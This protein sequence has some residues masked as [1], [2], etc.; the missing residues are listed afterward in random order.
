M[1]T[2]EH[3]T[4]AAPLAVAGDRRLVRARWHSKRFVVA[5]I[6]A[7]A[8]RRDHERPPVNLAFVLDRS[9]SMGG[10][11]IRLAAQA[12]EEGIGRLKPTDRFSVV[13]YD[14][15]IEVLV[16]GTHATSEARR[17]AVR[18]L[19][20][21]DARGSTNL[22]GGW[23]TGCEEVASALMA[24]G[25]N[26]TLL[27]SDGLANVGMT[28][29]DELARHA[30]ELRARGV[31]TSTFGVGDDFDEALLSAMAQG[32]GGHFYDI[33]TAEAIADHM[34]S[35]VGETLEVVARDVV[36][37]VTLPGSVR[38]ESLGAFP[39]REAGSR[40]LVAIGDLVS[41][42]EVEVPLRVFFPLGEV[43]ASVPA[44]FGLSDR[45]GVLDGAV[46]RLAWEYADDAA[47]DRQPRDREVDR[48]VARVFAA[49]ARQE[50]VGLNRAGD[51]EA[52][53]GVLEATAH[54]I[55]A[56]AAHDP[57]LRDIAEGLRR[58]G[59]YFERHMLERDRK[60][61]YAMSSYALQARAFD[62]RA[63][64]SGR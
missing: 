33:A 10:R 8:A 21:V 3:T 11:K 62:G 17:E 6:T 55:R 46:G 56:Y 36:L 24:E 50:A 30:S 14:D 52:A 64:R 61:A 38:V 20:E 7:P 35:E 48:V 15:R 2:H 51:F 47:N 37:E 22:G 34:S 16:R 43:G 27:L 12:V 4:P 9:G 58:E 45:D 40:T 44:V 29:R 57:E 19:R 32:G 42:Q 5:R 59:A 13:V 54:R 28:D 18:H 1:T 41:E 60:A 49:R 23:L 53:R 31:S 39:A 26:R 63:K 25:V